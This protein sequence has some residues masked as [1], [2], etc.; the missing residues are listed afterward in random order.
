MCCFKPLVN[1]TVQNPHHVAVP[2]GEFAEKCGFRTIYFLHSNL[3]DSYIIYGQL[4]NLFIPRC[5]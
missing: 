3:D 5:V 2:V 1:V 4:E